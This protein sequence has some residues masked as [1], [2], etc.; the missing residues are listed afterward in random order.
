MNPTTRCELCAPESQVAN[1][2]N[3]L[4]LG[5]SITASATWATQGEALLHTTI[6]SIQTREI[7]YLI[8]TCKIP[9]DL[10]YKWLKDSPVV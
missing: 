3:K 2:E 4:V 7:R 1:S 8:F 10:P 9:A 6:L 5:A